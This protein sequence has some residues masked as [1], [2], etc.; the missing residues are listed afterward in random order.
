MKLADCPPAMRAALDAARGHRLGVPPAHPADG[1]TWFAS[2]G[3]CAMCGATE[4]TLADDHCHI[5]GLHRGRLCVSCNLAE[6]RDE[7][8]E[9]VWWRLHA[10]RLA[11]RQLA[12]G[13]R[14]QL[15]ARCEVTTLPVDVLLLLNE[16]RIHY[17][18][19]RHAPRL[20]SGLDA[21]AN[22]MPVRSWAVA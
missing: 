7:D 3:E 6:G 16:A 4:L 14:S 2:P 1:D 22:A 10:P 19:R 9:W 12:T 15:L 13:G 21:M 8:A 17:W 5:T 18:G 11:D 20:Q